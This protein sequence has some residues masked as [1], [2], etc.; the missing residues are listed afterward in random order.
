MTRLRASIV[1]IGDEILAGYVRDTNSGWLA[2]RLRHHGVPLDRI[3]TVPDEAGAIIAHLRAEL[4]RSRPRLVLTSG[5]IGSTPDDLTMDAVAGL[6]GVGLV[7]HPELDARITAA[8]RERAA[9]GTETPAEQEEAIRSMALVPDGARLLP[10]SGGMAP[11]VAVDIDGG[12]DA[13]GAAIAVLPGIPSEL[14][15]ITEHSVEPAL[16]AGRGEPTHTEE[17]THPYPESVL[18]PLLRRLTRR[19]PDVRIGSYPGPDC[20]VRLTGDAEEVA[21]A[22]ELVRAELAR[23]AAEPGSDHLAE[24][25]R[26]HWSSET[27]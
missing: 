27:P 3:V 20:L 18:S 11:G 6:L 5:G 24:R 21:A 15:R 2:E 26:A 9:A 17:L 7:T 23:I 22:A 14:R 1:V 13:G 10:E 4:D 16:V 8:L 25:W 12:L 19:F